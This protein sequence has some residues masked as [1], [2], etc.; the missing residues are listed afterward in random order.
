MTQLNDCQKLCP[1]SWEMVNCDFNQQQEKK[2][3]LI[4][5]SYKMLL[6][7]WFGCNLDLVIVDFCDGL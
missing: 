1:R 6:R 7:Y 2:V 4:N 3:N 5:K